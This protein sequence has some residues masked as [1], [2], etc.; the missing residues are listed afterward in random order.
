MPLANE[1]NEYGVNGP[2]T[3]LGR[4]DR[5]HSCRYQNKC[6]NFED[7]YKVYTTVRRSI[8]GLLAQ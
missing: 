6:C 4:D 7:Q 5:P 1:H 8:Y 2:Q 3:L